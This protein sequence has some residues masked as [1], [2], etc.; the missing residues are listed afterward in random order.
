MHKGQRLQKQKEG[1]EKVLVVYD[2]CK[3]PKEDKQY[4]GNHHDFNNRA[5]R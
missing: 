3:K 2:A 5:N 4:V 1:E